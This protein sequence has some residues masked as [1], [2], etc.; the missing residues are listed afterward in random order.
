MF[1]P[2]PNYRPNIRHPKPFLEHTSRYLS[3]IPYLARLL[4]KCQKQ[5][6][7]TWKLRT[8][9]MI[10]TTLTKMNLKNLAHQIPKMNLKNVMHQIPKPNQI[11]KYQIPILAWGTLLSQS[12][13]LPPPPQPPPQ[14]PHP[15]WIFR[16]P[17]FEYSNLN[18]GRRVRKLP[19]RQTRKNQQE[20]KQC[21]GHF[22]QIMWTFLG[23][24]N[25]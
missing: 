14:P 4:N 10:N 25:A 2:N 12:K 6:P 22:W 9:L 5:A 3:L 19:S 18:Q 17:L 13:L 21:C 20:C 11:P 7:T 16:L 1:P 23:Q 15:I 8:T 24:N